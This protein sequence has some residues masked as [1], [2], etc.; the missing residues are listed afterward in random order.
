VQVDEIHRA[1]F[2]TGGHQIC[3]RQTLKIPTHG[4]RIGKQVIQPAT[5]A[6]VIR[7]FRRRAP[8]CSSNS[9]A[10]FYLEETNYVIVAAL[11]RF[12]EDAKWEKTN[13]TKFQPKTMTSQ[14][15]KPETSPGFSF[16]SMFA[17]LLCQLRAE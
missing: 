9:E 17:S 4:R 1:N 13:A 14:K 2:L 8:E 15:P 6:E 11:E 3:H 5:P 12:H 10:K 7:D 16:G